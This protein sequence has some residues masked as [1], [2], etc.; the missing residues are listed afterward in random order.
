MKRRKTMVIKIIK[1]ILLVFIV[2][3]CSAQD[4]P[5]TYNGGREKLDKFVKANMKWP[6]QRTDYMGIV[7]VKCTIDENG[8]IINPK[9]EKGLCDEC[10][11]E[12]LRLVKTM[13][14]WLPAQRKGERIPS[15]VLIP[16]DFSLYNKD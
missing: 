5:A 16:I 1:V 14:N 13:P 4:F 9:I 2:V 12:A 11:K 8:K 6:L 10:D 7:Y 15:E 3:S